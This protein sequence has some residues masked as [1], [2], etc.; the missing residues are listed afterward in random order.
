MIRDTNDEIETLAADMKVAIRNLKPNMQ[1]RKNQLFTLLYPA[2]V[3]MIAK[4]VTH[5]AILKT[6]EEKGLKLHP[7]RFKELMAANANPTG[8]AAVTQEE[9]A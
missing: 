2:I 8:R 7:S 4:N 9:A 1:H 3:E 5:K 6:L